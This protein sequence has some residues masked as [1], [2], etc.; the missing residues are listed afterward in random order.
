MDE[1]HTFSILAH[2]S[3]FCSVMNGNKVKRRLAW[4]YCEALTA[5]PFGQPSERALARSQSSFPSL[6]SLVSLLGYF[7]RRSLS[8]HMHATKVMV[9]SSFCLSFSC[10]FFFFPSRNGSPLFFAMTCTLLAS[11][12]TVGA[13]LCQKP[14]S[15][16]CFQFFPSQLKSTDF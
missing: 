1:Q 11:H 16:S 12:R 8:F 7:H 6:I 15:S 14:L 2:R 10:A 4:V 3:F 13:R 9:S 5:G